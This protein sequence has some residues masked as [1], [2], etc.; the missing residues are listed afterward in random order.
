MQFFEVAGSELHQLKQDALTAL[1]DDKFPSG[2]V[3]R[4]AAGLKEYGT[5][6]A[7]M[8]YVDAD[9]TNDNWIEALKAANF[10]PAKNTIC[11]AKGLTHYLPEDAVKRLI[12]NLQSVLTHPESRL[13]INFSPP[14]KKNWQWHAQM[15]VDNS[16]GARFKFSIAEAD[17]P[18]FLLDQGFQSLERLPNSSIYTSLGF[19]EKQAAANKLQSYDFVTRP[20]A[21]DDLV[22][23]LEQIP[24]IKAVEWKPAAPKP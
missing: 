17:A 14:P 7:N 2:S 5:P 13:V 22:K 8:H 11:F 16:L 15:H 20:K 18:K 24:V 6:A 10:D 23:S 19:T 3:K 21:P 1:R 4:A 12:G 9:I